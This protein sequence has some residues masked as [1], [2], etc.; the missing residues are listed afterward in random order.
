MS[1]KPVPGSQSAVVAVLHDEQ[2]DTSDHFE[3]HYRLDY[4]NGQYTRNKRTRLC[5]LNS[6][7]VL[8]RH[9][10]EVESNLLALFSL[11][12]RPRKNRWLFNYLSKLQTPLR[13]AD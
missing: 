7:Y 13:I 2:R 12:L 3:Q 8:R 1:L 5:K 4:L 10:G 11:C 6:T 9:I